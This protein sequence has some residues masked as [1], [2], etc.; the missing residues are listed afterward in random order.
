VRP[1]RN[2]PLLVVGEIEVRREDGSVE[3]LPRATLCRCGQ[4]NHKPFCDNEHIK[5]GFKAPGEPIR[6]HL[7]GVR[8][9]AEA[10]IAKAEDP[11]RDS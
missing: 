7:T 2:G 8:P 3:T 10:P 5:A 9:H 1:I 6:I 4:S 11:R